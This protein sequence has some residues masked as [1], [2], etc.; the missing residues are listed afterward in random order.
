MLTIETTSQPE[1]EAGEFL[2]REIADEQVP[3][4]LLVAGGSARR[5][6]PYI[7]VPSRTAH[8]T[9]TTLDERC[10]NNANDRNMDTLMQTPFYQACS[11]GGGST[12]SLSFDTEENCAQAAASFERSLSAW[13]DTH[14]NGS[15]VTL[16]G[17]GTNGHIAGIMP[18]RA[19]SEPFRE[20]LVVYDEVLPELDPF[21]KRITVTTRFLREWVNRAVVFVAGRE[22]APIVRHLAA[23][24]AHDGLAVPAC[25]LRHLPQVIV[26]TDTD[27]TQEIN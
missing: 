24:A 19:A 3:L 26:F 11:M 2:G 23:G 18:G 5:A 21:P 8:L 7:Q 14:P 9:V 1:R 25:V 27:Y 4:L 17:I 13:K 16:M 12:I 6:L 22:K 15:V 10:T 20:R